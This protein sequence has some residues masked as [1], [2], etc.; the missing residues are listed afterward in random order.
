V[1]NLKKRLVNRSWNLKPPKY[2]DLSLTCSVKNEHQGDIQVYVIKYRIWKTTEYIFPSCQSRC[3]YNE[4]RRNVTI[5]LCDSLTFKTESHYTQSCVTKV[6]IATRHTPVTLGHVSLSCFMCRRCQNH[7]CIW[8]LQVWMQ[9][10]SH[11]H[12]AM[13]CPGY[14]Y[15]HFRFA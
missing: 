7:I 4:L 15:I 12:L 2:E 8:G 9:C 14:W 1:I 6:F 13:T 11:C 5:C 10:L 3:W